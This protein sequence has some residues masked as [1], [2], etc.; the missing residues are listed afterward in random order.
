VSS[1]EKLGESPRAAGVPVTRE[2]HP[3]P[4]QGME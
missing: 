3:S 4:E 1:A 2:I